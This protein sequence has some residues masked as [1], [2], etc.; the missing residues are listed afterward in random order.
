MKALS[1]LFLASLFFTVSASAEV[2]GHD[3]LGGFTLGGKGSTPISDRPIDPK[4]MGMWESTECR[5]DGTC[6][7]THK[8]TGEQRI[9]NSKKAALTEEEKRK[10]AET[11]VETREQMLEKAALGHQDGKNVVVLQFGN[12]E[13]CAPC[14]QVN[15]TLTESILPKD[16]SVMVLDVNGMTIKDEPLKAWLVANK[17][18][19][20]TIPFPQIFILH[21]NDDGKGFST[22]KLLN[23]SQATKDGLEKTI[24]EVK[25]YHAKAQVAKSVGEEK[26]VT[27]S[28]ETPIK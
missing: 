5:S 14:Q 9:R 24:A 10:L 12:L 21:V 22:V 17:L 2:G 26:K 25:D 18:P 19:T 13:G 16:K 28:A 1:F 4:E 7:Y 6:I 8:V 15:K 23:R 11:E 27:A 3:I 20:G